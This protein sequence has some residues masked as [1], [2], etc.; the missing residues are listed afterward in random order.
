MSGEALIREL[1]LLRVQVYHPADEDGD[2]LVRHLKRI[3]CYVEQQWPIP[4]R[5][6]SST[7]V[8]FCLFGEHCIQ[9]VEN[10][11]VE[12]SGTIVAVVEYE[13]PTIIRTLLEADVQAVVGKPIRAFGV[14]STLV[15]ASSRYRFECR[16]AAKII[17]L[18]DTLRSRRVVNKAV[19]KLATEHAMGDE[20]A[21]QL[22]RRWS[23]ERQLSMTKIADMLLSD[24]GSELLRSN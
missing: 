14:M 19:R 17:K 16:Q 22:I 1:R 3:G 20:A 6:P 24:N 23:L 4:C 7:D 10:L 2:E 5:W 8:V 13:S 21:Y 15:V 9:D 11:R 12:R 18:E